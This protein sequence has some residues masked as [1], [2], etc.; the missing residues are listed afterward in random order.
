MKFTIENVATAV[1]IDRARKSVGRTCVIAKIVAWISGV[2]LLALTYPFAQWFAGQLQPL[3]SGSNEVS[4]QTVFLM[5][6]ACVTFV[7]IGL[8]LARW[9]FSTAIELDQGLKPLDDYEARELVKIVETYPELDKYRR[10]VAAVREFVRG[11]LEL[12]R[13]HE[14]KALK[15]AQE[16]K[17]ENERQ[18]IFSKLHRVD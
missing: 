15:M 5:S 8:R 6:I 2:V 7:P 16:A 14:Q 18:E 13:E 12:L 4:F 10:S 11:D 3:A 1:E 17:R 9:P